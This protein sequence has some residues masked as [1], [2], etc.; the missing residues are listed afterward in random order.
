MDRWILLLTW[1]N[2]HF[3][4]SMI[5]QIFAETTMPLAELTSSTIK[6]LCREI[7]AVNTAR[8]LSQFTMG[9]G[10]YTEERE[11]IFGHLTVDEIVTE[12]QNKRRNSQPQP[13]I[14]PKLK[15]KAISEAAL[16]NK[17]SS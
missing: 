2:I 9:Y 8:F 5:E 6:L 17:T 15:A 14:R 3:L 13:A 4:Q 12:I 1:I 10:N 7:G 11:E 16:P